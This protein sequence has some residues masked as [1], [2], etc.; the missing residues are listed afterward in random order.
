MSEKLGPISYKSPHE[1]VFIGRDYGHSKT[2]SEQVAAEI[3]DE[4]RSIIEHCY[5]RA[6]V[7]LQENTDKLNELANALLEKETIDGEEFEK[8]MNK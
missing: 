7:I 3:D 2:Y 5:Q 1:E 4:V 8:L 6:L